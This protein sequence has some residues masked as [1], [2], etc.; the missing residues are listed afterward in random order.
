MAAV[1]GRTRHCPV[2]HHVTQLLGFWSSWPLEALSSCGTGQSDVV[3]NGS[4]SLSGAPLTLW[5]WLCA[6]CSSLFIWSPR[7]YSRPLHEVAITPLAHRT[8]RWIIAECA[9]WNPR[10]ASWTLYGPGALDTVWYARP[11]HTWF[12]CSFVFESL[13]GIFIGLCW[14]FMHL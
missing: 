14:T 13:T 3:P 7:F 4:C 5:L 8:V 1:D 6:H 11:Q 10:V 9:C 12:L 2:C